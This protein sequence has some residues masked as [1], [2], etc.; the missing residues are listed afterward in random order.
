MPISAKRKND[1]GDSRYDREDGYRQY[2]TGSER[3]PGVPL[4]FSFAIPGCH[5]APHDAC[6]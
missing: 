5:K 2:R 6:G 1:P 3:F 4:L